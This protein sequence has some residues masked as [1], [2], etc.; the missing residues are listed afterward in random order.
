MQAPG[1]FVRFPSFY[2]YR[3]KLLSGGPSKIAPGAAS[4]KA[5]RSAP[6]AFIDVHPRPIILTGEVPIF[7]LR[8]IM[9]GT[10]RDVSSRPH[11]I[12][13]TPAH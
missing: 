7:P 2:M 12:V 4:L 11:L 3:T 6:S 10:A 5:F 8:Q 1:S 13:H 9:P